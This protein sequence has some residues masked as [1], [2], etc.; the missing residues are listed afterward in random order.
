M[1]NA[2]IMYKEASVA[3]EVRPI[4][5]SNFKLSVAK[6]LM[7][8]ILQGIK[9]SWAYCLILVDVI[10]PLTIERAREHQMLWTL[11]LDKEKILFACLHRNSSNQS[12]FML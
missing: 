1:T 11:M 8:A 12:C 2:L 5:H 6:S 10:S 9:N 4:S 3:K 7:E